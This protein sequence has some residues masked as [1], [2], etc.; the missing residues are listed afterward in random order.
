MMVHTYNSSTQKAKARGLWVQGQT[1]QKT[2]PQ[3]PTP[4]PPKKKNPQQHETLL[5]R[6]LCS[7]SAHRTS[8]RTWVLAPGPALVVHMSKPS[9]GDGDGWASAPI[10]QQPRLLWGPSVRKVGRTQGTSPKVVFWLLHIWYVP[11]HTQICHHNTN[12]QKI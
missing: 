3:Q 6:Q 5:R 4:A 8:M 12:T 10:G 2:L 9:Q 11:E 1:G 7:G